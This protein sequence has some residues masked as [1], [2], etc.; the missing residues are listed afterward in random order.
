MV[1]FREWGGDGVGGGVGQQASCSLD[2]ALVT[3]PTSPPPHSPPSPLWGPRSLHPP[4]GRWC[5]DAARAAVGA[6]WANTQVVDRINTLQIK[7]KMTQPQT[8]QA[9][10]HPQV[11]TN[12]RS[13]GGSE[14]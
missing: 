12:S 10:P 4:Q 7:A 1:S 3:P 6:S 11:H 8:Q 14:G 9:V 13:T 5:I 2:L